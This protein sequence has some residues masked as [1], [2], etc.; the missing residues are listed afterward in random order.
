MRS[1]RAMGDPEGQHTELKRATIE[2]RVAAGEG[3]WQ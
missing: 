1:L 2:V 3:P